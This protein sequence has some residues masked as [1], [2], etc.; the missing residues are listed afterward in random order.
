MDKVLEEFK[1]KYPN[2]RKEDFVK[3]NPFRKIG[4]QIPP[5]PKEIL[6]NDPKLR[7]IC[8]P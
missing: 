7:H 3:D 4:M 2:L 5:I 8:R 1:R 6:E